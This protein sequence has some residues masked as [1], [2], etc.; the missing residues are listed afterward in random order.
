MR[1]LEEKRNGGMLESIVIQTYCY[2]VKA[3]SV[4]H[5]IK[6]SLFCNF[7]PLW[8][9][10]LPYIYRG[11]TQERKRRKENIAK[12]GNIKRLG[13]TRKRKKEIGV[14]TKRMHNNRKT[15]S[16]SERKGRAKENVYSSGAE[17]DVYS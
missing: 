4:V 1:R 2:M 7:C 16:K 10:F 17:I 9:Y 3:K 15:E 11:T 12:K 13:K 6:M 14:Q 5:K 8:C